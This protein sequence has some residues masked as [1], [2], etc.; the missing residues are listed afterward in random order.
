MPRLLSIILGAIAL[1]AAVVGIRALMPGGDSTPDVQADRIPTLDKA[2]PEN[3][4]QHNGAVIF[5][6]SKAENKPLRYATIGE[7]SAGH[8]AGENNA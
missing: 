1:I 2:L 7:G 3:P 5:A 4:Q 8:L 6:R